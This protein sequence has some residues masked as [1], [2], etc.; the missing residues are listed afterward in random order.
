MP[1]RIGQI[2]YANCT[3]VFRT[4]CKSFD[5]SRYTFH[6]GVPSDLNRL[7]ARGDI[8]VCP[9][10]SVI[11]AQSPESYLILPGVS[12][13]ACGPVK[14]VLLFSRVPVEELQ[15]RT[16][17]LTSESDTSVNLL[18]IILRRFYGYS[19]EFVR[20]EGDPS[21]DTEAFL[22]IGDRALKQGMH[23]SG[24][25]VYDLAEIWN[26]ET[27]LPFVFALW[28][29]RRGAVERYPEEV[30]LLQRQL[31]AAKLEAAGCFP[32][33]ASNSPEGEWLGGSA[34]V[35][36][37]NTISYDLGPDHLRGLATFY[38]YAAELGLISTPPE[39]RL[40]EP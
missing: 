27:G 19:N 40:L 24:L 29:V 10:S 3:P 20:V 37:W 32:E 11:Y 7:L 22:L 38:R 26:R 33:L 13:S 25:F 23:S 5:C 9:S 39:L 34:L 35:D 8:D 1:L 6:T 12:I 36:Y 4:L 31:A 28:L 30:A 17:G 18:K 16:V 21:A 2:T 14:S 15:G